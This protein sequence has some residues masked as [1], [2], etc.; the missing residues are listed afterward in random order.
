MTAPTITTDPELAGRHAA[1][2]RDAN[3]AYF[4]GGPEGGQQPEPWADWMAKA[5]QGFWQ[6]E[7]EREVGG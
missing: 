1:A 4:T 7:R 5:A 2:M 6:A 3:E